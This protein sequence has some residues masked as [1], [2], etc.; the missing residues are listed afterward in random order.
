MRIDYEKYPSLLDCFRYEKKVHV[1]Y[2]TESFVNGMNERVGNLCTDINIYP[3]YY[4]GVFLYKDYV[5]KYSYDEFTVT[6]RETSENIEKYGSYLSYHGNGANVEVYKGYDTILEGGQLSMPLTQD[7]YEFVLLTQRLAFF[8]RYANIETK[9]V[10]KNTV[11]G[12]RCV[13][14]KIHSDFDFNIEVV[15]STWF[16]SIIREKGFGVRGHFRLQ[17]CGEGLK[18][19]KLIWINDFEKT[20]YTR[21][22]G[23]LKQEV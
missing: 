2:I 21:I 11:S 23:K 9:I 18:E 5:I 17:P 1:K 13:E 14:D 4:V 20:G 8:I 3:D 19:K 16:T 22:A 7:E 15:D 6:P 12:I 10:N